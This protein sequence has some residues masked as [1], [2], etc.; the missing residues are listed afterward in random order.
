MT[1]ATRP[2]GWRG[3]TAARTWPLLFPLGQGLA[4]GIIFIAVYLSAFH[5]PQPRHVPVT[6]VGGPAAAAVARQPAAAQPG[7]WDFIQE[8]S[9]AAA[10]AAVTHQDAHAA[11]T[12][13]SAVVLVLADANGPSVTS[14]LTSRFGA[15][16]GRARIRIVLG[17]AET[18]LAGP[19]FGALPGDRTVVFGL[20]AL[21]LVAV[22][23][24]A[25]LLLS[26]SRTFGAPGS[27]GWP[28]TPC[29]GRCTS[30]EHQWAPRSSAWRCGLSSRSRS[31]RPSPGCAATAPRFPAPRSRSLRDH[32]GR[33]RLR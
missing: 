23:G 24:T 3:L 32:C 10:V 9:A 6:V 12:G 5:S 26:I 16:A 17:A 31:A 13:R 20:L 30:T 25:A 19:V 14:Q 22:S 4:I 2:A 21:L 11:I 15:A 27:T 1:R 29:A 33:G 7:A 18:L 8:A 28:S